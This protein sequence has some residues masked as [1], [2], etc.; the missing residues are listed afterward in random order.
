MNKA[1]EQALLTLEG[2]AFWS[3]VRTP[4]DKG[5]FTLVLGFLDTKAKNLLAAHGI[6]TSNNNGK[7]YSYGKNEGKPKPDQGDFITLKTKFEVPVFNSKLQPM[8]DPTRIGN[9]S[10]VR[11]NAS[12]YDW[13]NEQGKKG[14]S[15]GLVSVQVLQLKEFEG[16]NPL[17]GLTAE[18]DSDAVED[19][20]S[21]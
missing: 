16:R 14:R 11:V 19:D 6:K 12:P 10:K 5:M 7:V 4:D 1:A 17:E 13:K 2:Q 9:G 8:S 3:K 21:I 18:E 20:D 15:A